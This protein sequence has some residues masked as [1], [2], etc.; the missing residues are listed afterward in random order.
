MDV[1]QRVSVIAL[2]FLAIILLN[3]VTNFIAS[4]QI[5]TFSTELIVK[6]III[7]ILMMALL[8]FLWGIRRIRSVTLDGNR[9]KVSNGLVHYS[10]K[11]PDQSHFESDFYSYDH[12]HGMPLKEGL[13]SDYH[14]LINGIIRLALF[15]NIYH[16]VVMV[17][18]KK[19]IVLIKNI[20]QLDAENIVAY[21]N[22]K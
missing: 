21:L 19:R 20:S 8:P 18:G 16:Q 5:R 7:A 4:N 10:Y 1:K 11:I 2:V 3:C 6:G 15:K 13:A 14:T 22:S 12:Q 9:V 17:S